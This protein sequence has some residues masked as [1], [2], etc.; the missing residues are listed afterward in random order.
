RRLR[1]PAAA[2]RR[3]ITELYAI[4]F[5]DP[6]RWAGGRFPGLTELFAPAARAGVR[7][8][9]PELTLGR[10][11]TRLSAVRPRRARLD[12]RFLL[13]R[14]AHP[15]TAV[16]GVR[17]AGVGLTEAP[18]VR[19]PIAQ[20]GRYVLQRIAGAWRIVSFQVDSHL[21][22]VGAI[23]RRVRRASLSPPVPSRD[24]LFVLVIGSDA[25]RGQSVT[26]TRAD[27]LHIVGVN[28]GRGLVSVLGIPRD[29]YVAIPGHGTAKINSALVYGG[30]ELAV[31]TVEALSGI[32]IDAYVLTG[33]DGFTHLVNAVGGIRTTIP[34]PMSDA[35]SRAHFAKG[36][37]RLDGRNALAFS[38]D[39]HDA[40]GGDVGRSR[41]QGRLMV[42]AMREFRSDLSH[43]PAALIR[44]V[45][46]GARYLRT[47]LDLSEMVELLLSVP[48]VDAAHVRNDVVPGSGGM[49]GGQ[50]VIRLGSG[51]AAMFRDLRQD[52]VLHG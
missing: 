35:A 32:P 22:S 41:N 15:V 27:S 44:W 52:A 12:V 30:P 20:D 29:S 2:I 3:S 46:A 48:S 38:R 5:V 23:D 43:D 18:T 31:R 26:A 33:F 6:K 7:R 49:V 42:S 9:L 40:P 45:L 21:P 37:K 8:D 14:H 47:D 16:A 25:R 50:S 19:A 10:L 24:P 39:R 51:A 1:A 11:A 13:D 28:P 17:F 36:P 4:G 34:Y